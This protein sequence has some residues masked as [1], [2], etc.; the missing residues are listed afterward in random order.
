MVKGL[1]RLFQGSPPPEPPDQIH[2]VSD[3]LNFLERVDRSAFILNF[4]ETVADNSNQY[5]DKDYAKD[6]AVQNME[7]NHPFRVQRIRIDPRPAAK[8]IFIRREDVL[9]VGELDPFLFVVK[10]FGHI[11]N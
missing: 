10:E 3:Q 9:P 5:I 11:E 1:P 2:S 7:A 8:H 4:G 6:K